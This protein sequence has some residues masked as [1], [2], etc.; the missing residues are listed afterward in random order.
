M[1]NTQAL[2]VQKLLALRG[3]KSITHKRQTLDLS[4]HLS[5]FPGAL[6]AEQ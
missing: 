1:D 4:P 3:S 5:H 6:A 2:F